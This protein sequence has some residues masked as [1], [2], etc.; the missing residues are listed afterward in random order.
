MH[1]AKRGEVCQGCW[2]GALERAG[3]RWRFSAQFRAE[4]VRMVMRSGRTITEVAGDL[5]VERKTLKKWVS[6]FR[7]PVRRSRWIRFG[8]RRWRP[9]S[10]GCGWRTSS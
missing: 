9:R 1:R 8:C 6:E 3:R 10:A 4:A 5:G 2:T 7:R